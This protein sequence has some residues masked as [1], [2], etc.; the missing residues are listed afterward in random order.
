MF[1]IQSRPGFTVIVMRKIPKKVQAEVDRRVA[2]GQCLQCSE[3]AEKGKKGL[4]GPHYWKRYRTLGGL[5][6]EQLKLKDEKDIADGKI[7][8]SRQGQRP[9]RASA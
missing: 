1:T 8:K 4:C 9:E 5:T 6:E 3:P 2:R 7:L